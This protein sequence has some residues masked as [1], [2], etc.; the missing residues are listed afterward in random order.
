VNHSSTSSETVTACDSYVWHGTTYTESGDYTFLSQNNENCTNT[1]TLH[2]TINH[3][4][5]SSESVTAC[6]SYIWHGTTYTTSGDYT[7]S[8]VNSENCTNVATLHLTIN[9]LITWY[10]DTDEDGY[11]DAANIKYA[12]TKPAG[13]VAN[14]YDCD[15]SRKEKKPDEVKVMM[16]HNGKP[17]CVIA[18]EVQKKLGD[19][20]QLGPCMPPCAADQTI[21]CHDGRP[22]CVKTKDAEKKL[23]EKGGHWTRSCDV[24]VQARTTNAADLAVNSPK[25]TGADL[26]Y[27]LTNYPNPFS[28]S[29]V[30][31][32]SIPADSK[33]SLKVFNASGQAVATL[34]EGIKK[35]GSYT[36]NFNAKRFS[37]G[38]YYCKLVAISNGKQVVKTLKLSVGK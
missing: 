17:E 7:Y 13:Y 2:L 10:A 34:F 28:V 14:N 5:T 36:D 37:N 31:S 25:A 23:N 20:W 27:Y 12:C 29:T 19:G 38:F 35:A 21:L 16:C 15:D 9:P 33:V 4:S 8:S 18:K 11:G 26:N 24:Y 32:Y 22:E 1:A 30:I 6:D 3:S